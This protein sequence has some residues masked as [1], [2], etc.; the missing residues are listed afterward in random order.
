MSAVC[1][2]SAHVAT[3]TSSLNGGADPEGTYGVEGLSTGEND[4]AL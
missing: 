2:L 1:L 4:S 3:P